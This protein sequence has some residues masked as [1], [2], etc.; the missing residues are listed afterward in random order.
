MSW[1]VH[2]RIICQLSEIAFDG[3]DRCY[4]PHRLRKK[5]SD[6]RE[7]VQRMNINRPRLCRSDRSVYRPDNG[8]ISN[9]AGIVSPQRRIIIN[10]NETFVSRRN[11]EK[12]VKAAELV[13]S[14]SVGF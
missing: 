7:R 8:S 11:D 3:I 12:W 5:N 6:L 10:C 1:R 9:N 13:I 2:R 4:P 14:I